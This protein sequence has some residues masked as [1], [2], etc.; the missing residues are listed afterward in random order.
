MKKIVSLALAASLLFSAA[1]FV[2]SCGHKIEHRP[3]ITELWVLIAECEMLSPA[4]HTSAS[5][6][7]FAAALSHAKSV[8]GSTSPGAALITAATGELRTAKANLVTG[9][10]VRED[11]GTAIN[12]ASN[13]P[14]SGY[15]AASWAALQNAITAARGAYGNPAST[16][17]Q[18]DAALQNLFVA[19]DSLAK[20]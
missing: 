3:Q 13:W 8:A 2:A 15:T 5:W 4:G 20:A 9:A 18:L 14:N 19:F 1:S 17:D 12:I 11:L 7:P 6:A 16:A 10:K